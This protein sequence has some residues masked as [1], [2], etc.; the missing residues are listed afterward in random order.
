[1]SDDLQAATFADTQRSAD[2]IG[3]PSRISPSA[4]RSFYGNPKTITALLDTIATR[5]FPS[6]I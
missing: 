3:A 5:C 6:T 1:M 4:T 2:I